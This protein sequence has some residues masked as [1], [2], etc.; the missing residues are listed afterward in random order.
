MLIRRSAI[1]FHKR[2]SFFCVTWAG[3]QLIY[4]YA[5]GWF[6]PI[7]YPLIIVCPVLTAVFWFVLPVVG[8]R[9]SVRTISNKHYSMLR[10]MVTPSLFVAFVFPLI[11][12]WVSK[13]KFQL[14]VV[15]ALSLS[16]AFSLIL[17]YRIY[18]ESFFRFL[19]GKSKV[20]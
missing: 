5:F 1:A 7:A 3:F 10:V 18:G 16:A 13:N 2:L 8:R 12:Y 17:A 14:G 20:S 11:F 15:A 9:S 19:E 6:R 4:A